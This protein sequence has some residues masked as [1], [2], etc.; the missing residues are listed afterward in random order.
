MTK[1]LRLSNE[2]YQNIA[3]DVIGSPVGDERFIAWTPVAEVYG[4]DT[5]SATRIDA[6]ALDEQLRTAAELAVLVLDSP[7]LT[8]ACPSRLTPAAPEDGVALTWT[9]CGAAVMTRF[10][11]RA[12]RRPLRPEE[13]TRYQSLLESSQLEAAAASLPH[14]FYE[15]LTTAVQAALLSPHVM[16]KPELV[17]GGF[18]PAERGYRIASKLALFFRSSVADDELWE[19]AGSGELDDPE[20]VE[21]QARR[22]L[23]QYQER[24]MTDFGGQW[25]DFRKDATG[26]DPLMMSMK[27][28]TRDVFREVLARG[29]TPQ[30]L[31]QPGFTIVDQRLAAHYGLE[32]DLDGEPVQKVVT[33]ERG[34]LLSQG[35][36]LRRTATGSE[37]RR[38]IHRGLWALTRLL[39][40][41]MP[42]LDAATVAEISES[43]EKIDR[44]L[45]L[46]EQMEFHRE[47]S[48]SCIACHGQID[49]VGLALEKY[50]RQGLW[51]EI[52]DN[53]HAIVSDLEL[54]GEVVA[55]PMTLAAAIEQS[56]EYRTC[57]ATKALTYALHRGPLANEACVARELAVPKDGS[58][59][60]L[61]ELAVTALLK[62]LELA[63]IAR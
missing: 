33:D 19:L 41:E 46:S 38:P 58:S 1:L 15:G 10:A 61:Q 48:G 22:M 55:D 8:S 6:R 56:E 2:E 62:S 36:F 40:R 23:A 45:P 47:A 17:P 9:N 57:V 25:L 53:G 14:P 29:L 16:F 30:K 49:P 35:Y 13:R 21:Q 43:F 28:E 20:I 50:D 27:N 52:D 12:F 63:D 26:G 24:F 39:C 18:E 51:R 44:T 60:S 54:L 42:R 37:F 32:F 34:G 5:M 4:F 7:E 11:S 31:L 59:P 3:S